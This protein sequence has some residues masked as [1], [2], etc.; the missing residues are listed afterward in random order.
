MTRISVCIATYNGGHYIKQQI[1]SIL[2][3]LSPADEIIISDD[4]ST[5]DTIAIIEGYGDSRILLL[6]G[7]KFRNPVYN[8]ENA[9]KRATGD[10]LF[11]SDQDDVWDSQK[12]KVSLAYLEKSDLVLSDCVI[13]DNNMKSIE[14]SFFDLNSSRPGFFKNLLLKNAYMGC[15]MAFRRQV[16]NKAMPFPPKLPMHDLWIGLIAEIYFTP[17]FVPQKLVLYRRHLDNASS[18]GLKSKNTFFEK[19][20]I[21]IRVSVL[22][23]LKLTGLSFRT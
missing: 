2:C 9:L 1:D 4:S 3:Q 19:M 16:I 5:D 14:R 21:R 23:I 7:Q 10:I 17:I 13:V 18:T 20:K 22:L 6:K 8:F 12:V 15:C 11:L